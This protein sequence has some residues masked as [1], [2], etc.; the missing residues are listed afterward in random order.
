MAL[1]TKKAKIKVKG[2]NQ[3]FG[4]IETLHMTEM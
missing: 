4:F 1:E 2:Q 3:I